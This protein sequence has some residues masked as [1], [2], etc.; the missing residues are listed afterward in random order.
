MW[1]YYTHTMGR[2]II[3]MER[4]YYTNVELLRTHTRGGEVVLKSNRFHGD[5]NMPL[6][7]RNAIRKGKASQREA[8]HG[9]Q[10]PQS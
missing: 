3:K 8:M 6:L 2:G 7:V 1:N 5:G 9:G 10:T 4:N